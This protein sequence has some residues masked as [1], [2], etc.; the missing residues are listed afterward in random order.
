MLFSIWYFNIFQVVTSFKEIGQSRQLF[1]HFRSLQ[2]PIVNFST[3]FNYFNVKAIDVVP[4]NWALDL[5]PG[6][7]DGSCSRIH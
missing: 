7:Q 2:I 6:I 1:V 4:G 3:N 5:N